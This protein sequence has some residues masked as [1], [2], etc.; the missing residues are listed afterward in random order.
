VLCLCR[1]TFF[2]KR[3]EEKGRKEAEEEEEENEEQEEE[4][5]EEEEEEV[6]EEEEEEEMKLIVESFRSKKKIA[7]LSVNPED[8]VSALKAAFH[9]QNPQYYPERQKFTTGTEPTSLVLEDGK[10]IQ[11]YNFGEGAIIYFKDLG[12]QISWK[13]VFLIEY[14]GPIIIY[15]LFALQPSQ[16]YG[17]SPGLSFVQ[18]LA[19][20]AWLSH[21]IKRELETLFVHRFSHAT[22][23]RFNL[24]KNCSYYWGFAAFVA[25]FVN[26]P[27][28]TEPSYYLVYGGLGLFVVS[29]ISN[30]IT[31]LILR[32]LRPA[33]STQRKIPSGFLFNLVSC[34]NYFVEITAW[35]GFSIMTQ[36]FTAYLFTLA[37]AAQMLEWAIKKHKL[38]KKEFPDYPR[39]RKIVFPFI[40]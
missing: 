12:P 21:Y 34:P 7:E 19:L 14:F 30:F 16:I 17:V 27:R 25:Y 10:K 20:G 37:G 4:D 6:E 24:I 15:G 31:H 32:N 3:R 28:F 40:Y 2:N 9:K 5:E 18:K 22:M 33:G 29:E 38:Y 8:K 1:P 23:P 39:S 35:I 36:T 13:T 26:H 11:E